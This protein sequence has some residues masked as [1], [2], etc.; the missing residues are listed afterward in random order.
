LQMTEPD[1]NICG[2]KWVDEIGKI[3]EKTIFVRFVIKEL[4]II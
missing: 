1:R 3:H 2:I 4:K